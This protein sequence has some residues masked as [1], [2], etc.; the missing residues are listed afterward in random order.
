MRTILAKDED[1]IGNKNGEFIYIGGADMVKIPHIIKGI[2]VTSYSRMFMDS[3]VTKVLSDNPDITD[4][5]E[6]FAG[7]QAEKLEVR[8]LSTGVKTMRGMF[9]EAQAKKIDL[10]HLNTSQVEDMGYMF[11]FSDVEKLDMSRFNTSKVTNME[12]MFAWTILRELDLS[13]FDTS[14]VVNMQSMLLQCR[15]PIAY[16]KV[17]AELEKLKLFSENI[18]SMKIISLQ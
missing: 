18:K 17:V 11:A 13:S 8:C 4:M 14:A 10:R 16:V 3:T 2:P 12:Y 5:S 9:Y 1:F 6:M 7:S 15:A